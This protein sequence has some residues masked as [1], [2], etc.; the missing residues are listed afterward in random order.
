MSI[1]DRF[2]STMNHLDASGDDEAL[3]SEAKSVGQLIELG[4]TGLKRTGGYVD[5]EFLPQLRGRKAVAVFKEMADNDP[6]VGAWLFTVRNLIRNVEW[7]VEPGGKTAQDEFYRKHVEQCMDDM[8]M[9]WGDFIVEALSMIEYGWSWHEIVYKRRLGLWSSDGR[10]RSKHNDGLVGWRKLPI[11]AQETMLRWVFD[12]TG[13]VRAMIQLAP[14]RYQTVPLPIERSLLFRPTLRKGNPEGVSLLRNAY[15]PWFMKKRLEEF[16]AVGIERDLAGLPIVGVPADM[17][18]AER[19]SKQYEA[20]QGFTKMVKSVRRNEQEG[21]VFPKAYDQETKQPLY[22]F[23]L[24]GGG[25]SRA[26]NVDATIQRYAQQILMSVL[27]DFIL[28]G[29]EGSGSYSMHV[30]KTGIFRTAMNALTQQIADV[31]NR[32]AIPRLMAVN[33]WRPESLPKLVPSDVDAP[34]IAVLSQFMTAMA[35]AGVTWFPDPVME[36]FVRSAARLP[37]LDEDAEARRKAMQLRTEATQFAQVTSEYLM[38]QQEAEMAT[39]SPE[40][41]ALQQG[42]AEGLGQRAAAEAS[43]QADQMAAEQAAGEE[44]LAYDRA[45]GADQAGEQRQMAMQQQA[46]QEEQV[47]YDRAVA[48]RDRTDQKQEARRAQAEQRQSAAREDSH[49]VQDRSLKRQELASRERTTLAQLKAKA[50]Q[51]KTKGA[52][53]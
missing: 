49:R 36:N 42:T 10:M 28:V 5:E 47:A 16:E 24:L 33:G 21:L 30:D 40:E 46:G 48:E 50:A 22:T 14:P 8:S 44:Q 27:A 31:F 20:V 1:D 37:K 43:G 51:T 32:H 23:E 52:K 17:L 18:R 45:A 9:A 26:F 39:M 29:H 6:I 25:G 38:A 3:V 19:G 11:R 34:D 35:N 2:I 53:K 12:E 41:Q 7:R 13:D 15:R 4:V